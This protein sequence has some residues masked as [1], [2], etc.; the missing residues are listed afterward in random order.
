[1]DF[2]FNLQLSISKK[3]VVQLNILQEQRQQAAM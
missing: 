3:K 1:M 2:I